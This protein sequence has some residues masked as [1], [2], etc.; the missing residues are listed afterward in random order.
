MGGGERNADVEDE[1]HDEGSSLPNSGNLAEQL[2]E[3]TDA[4]PKLVL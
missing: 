2:E 3:M 4:A 1:I